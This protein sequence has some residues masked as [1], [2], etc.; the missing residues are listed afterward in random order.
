MTV[1]ASSEVKTGCT[2]NREVLGECGD[3]IKGSQEN[4]LCELFGLVFWANSKD[5]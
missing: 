1:F 5:E 4:G 2:G 3:V